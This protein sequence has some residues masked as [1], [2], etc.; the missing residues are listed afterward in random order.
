MHRLECHAPCCKAGKTT[1]SA[2]TYPFK[3][4]TCTERFKEKLGLS[5]HKSH[6]HPKV[7]NQHQID[8]TKREAERKQEKRLM[9]KE[10]EK[11]KVEKK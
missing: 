9:A 5:Q 8:T 6:R 11:H 3:C 10:L 4:E 7:A 1:P 2:A